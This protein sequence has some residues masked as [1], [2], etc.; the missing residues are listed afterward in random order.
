[1]IIIELL[2]LLGIVILVLGFLQYQ[3]YNDVFKTLSS[4]ISFNTF[5]I[6]SITLL[7]Y[8]LLRFILGI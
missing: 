2:I 7:S 1:M 5:L 4:L 8:T 3:K 6:I